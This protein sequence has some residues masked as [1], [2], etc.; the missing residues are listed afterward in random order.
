MPP[1]AIGCSMSNR[2]QT[3]VRIMRFSPKIRC[4]LCVGLFAARSFRDAA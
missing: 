4:P 2:S 3:G 1:S